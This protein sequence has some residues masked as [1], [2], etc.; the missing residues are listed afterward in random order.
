M[1]SKNRDDTMT[2]EEHLKQFGFQY[3]HEFI[4]VAESNIQEII[5]IEKHLIAIDMLGKTLAKDCD[6]DK[7]YIEEQLNENRITRDTLYKLLPK[8]SYKKAQK[9]IEEQFK[10]SNINPNLIRIS[11]SDLSQVQMAKRYMAYHAIGMAFEILF[12]TAILLESNDFTHTHKISTLYTELQG[13]KT[14]FEN[15]IIAHGWQTVDSFTAYLD[16]YFTNPNNKYFETYL[17][18]NDEHEH[19][20]Q[21]INLF[22][23][24]SECLVKYANQNNVKKPTDWTYPIRLLS[25]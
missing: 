9:Y 18:F 10:E 20:K 25:R 7:K 21:L 13:L 17:T 6:I 11:Q 23:K 4:R 19:P 2:G 16:N 14:E 8:D 15:I 22:N 1:M 12:K 5:A 3:A 24:I